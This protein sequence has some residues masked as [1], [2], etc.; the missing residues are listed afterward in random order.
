M[1]YTTT[2]LPASLRDNAASLKRCACEGIALLN[3]C[4]SLNPEEEMRL[5]EWRRTLNT[6]SIWI[7]GWN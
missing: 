1:Q 6:K 2:F 4:L 3:I 7:Q 5:K